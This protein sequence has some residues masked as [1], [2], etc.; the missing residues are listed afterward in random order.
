[1]TVRVHV[2]EEGQGGGYL[3]VK[4]KRRHQGKE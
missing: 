4:E 1:M 3:Q 2:S